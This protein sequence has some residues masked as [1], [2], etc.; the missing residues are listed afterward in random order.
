MPE[1]DTLPTPSDEYW[2]R[3]ACK[4]FHYPGWSAWEAEH[5]MIRAQLIAHEL[6]RQMREA[7][8]AEKRLEKLGKADEGPRAEAPWDSVRRQFF[9]SAGHNIAND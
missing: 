5:P 4:A 3:E 9:G 2:E 6:H 7:Y 8:H 1:K